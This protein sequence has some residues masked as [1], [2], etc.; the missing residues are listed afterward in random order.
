MVDEDIGKKLFLYLWT[1]FNLILDE[2]LKKC[3]E[4]FGYIEAENVAMISELKQ[5]TEK[6]ESLQQKIGDKE[7]IPPTVE[8][9]KCSKSQVKQSKS[10]AFTTST[11]KGT[12][13]K[14]YFTDQLLQI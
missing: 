3:D 9:E 10:K 5:L 2:L 1:K 11:T 8:L 12:P 13:K 14:R 6:R 4:K 7:N